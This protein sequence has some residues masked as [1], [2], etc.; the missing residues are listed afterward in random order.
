MYGVA[1]YNNEYSRNL[2]IEIASNDGRRWS[3][4]FTDSLA[5]LLSYHELGTTR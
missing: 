4:S 1:S 5:V 2:E 3:L